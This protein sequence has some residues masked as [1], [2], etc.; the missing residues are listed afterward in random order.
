MEKLTGDFNYVQDESPR[1]VYSG[2]L[3][4]VKINLFKGF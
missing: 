1:A 3:A 4:R 2:I